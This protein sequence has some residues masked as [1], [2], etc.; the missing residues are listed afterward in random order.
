ERHI[1]KGTA[2]MVGAAVA[3]VLLIRAA[4]GTPE[5]GDY[6]A[7]ALLLIAFQLALLPLAAA[8]SRR[9]ER[10]ADDYSLQLTGDRDAYIRTHLALARK[11]LADLDPPRLAYLVLFTHPTPPERLE[12]VTYLYPVAC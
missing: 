6:P 3:G 4:L 8:L 12:L 9:W 11:N 10:T 2:L 7:V 5:P 1:V